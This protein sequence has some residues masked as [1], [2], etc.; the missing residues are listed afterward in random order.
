MS[1]QG[2]CQERRRKGPAIERHQALEQIV[3]RCSKI[4]ERTTYD[5]GDVCVRNV[6]PF[7]QYTRG[8]QRAELTLPKAIERGVTFSSLDVA[9][10]WH[11]QVVPSHPVRRSVVG[12]EHQD[13]PL[14]VALEQ[15]L[16]QHALRLGESLDLLRPA[17]TRERAAPF[18]AAARGDNELAPR[19]VGRRTLEGAK[20][21]GKHRSLGS[22]LRPLLGIEWG[23]QNDEQSARAQA[24]AQLAQRLMLIFSDS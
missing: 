3:G 19:A 8:D 12:S 18:L 14:A 22:V 10:E 15:F 16:E 17:P 21:A 23:T 20:D 9:G 11:D 24:I 7:V 5:D 2:A 4:S 1:E 13:A 6:E